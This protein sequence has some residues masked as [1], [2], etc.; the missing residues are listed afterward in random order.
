MS[1]SATSPAKSDKTDKAD[2]ADKAEKP[3]KVEKSEKAKTAVERGSA[4]ESSTLTPSFWVGDLDLRAI[5]LFRIGFGLVILYDLLDLLP[6][7]RSWFSDAGVMPRNVLLS[8]MIRPNRFS[9]SDAFGAPEMMYVYWVLAFIAAICVIIGYRTRLM[10]F[11]LYLFIAGFNER[12]PQLFDGSDSVVRLSLF[13]LC[14]CPSNH[15]YS[16]DAL[17]AAARGQPY[18]KTGMAL[19][20]RLLQGQIAWVYLCSFFHKLGGNTWHLLDQTGQHVD[21]NN[22]ALHYVL[23]LNHVFARPWASVLAD[24]PVPMAIGTYYTLIFESSFLFLVFAPVFNRYLKALALLMG[25]ALH[26]GIALTVNVGL[27]SYLMPVTYLCFLEPDWV[28]WVLDKLRAFTNKT[29][30][31]VLYDGNCPICRESKSMVMKMDRFE[32]L[33]F[34]DFR[35]EDL[36]AQAKELKPKVL[37]KRMHVVTNEGKVTAGF[38]AVASIFQRVPATFAVAPL[39][40]LPGVFQLGSSIY[41][42]VADRRHSLSGPCTDA[43]CA[44]HT[45]PPPRVPLFS[46]GTRNLVRTLGFMG[47]TALFV[48]TAWYASPRDMAKHLP[49]EA[50]MTVQWFSLWNIWDMFSPEPLRT[51]YHLRAVAEYSDGSTGDLFGGPAGG[52]GEVRGFW[53]SRWWKYLENVTGGGETMPREWGRWQCREHNFN[54]KPGEPMLYTFTLKK[55]N[56]IIPPIGQP[57]PP[58]QVADVWIHRCYDKPQDKQRVSSTNP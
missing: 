30:A 29:P 39:M 46:E 54:L 20:I 47:L 15:R 11:V 33:S 22:A 4:G 35:H 24:Y 34:V 48:C 3:V 27:F 10:Q 41:D 17:R 14:W 5:G 31:T 53:F 44:V 23:H 13:W 49:R 16:F 9:L 8:E 26:G 1:A 2:K 43:T 36:P 18:S 40:T 21:L 52:P 32:R 28:E 51:D 45:S 42:W 19:P 37:E 38:A 7:V 50:E 25:V 55:E 58:V 56:Q 12:L 6:H 57:W